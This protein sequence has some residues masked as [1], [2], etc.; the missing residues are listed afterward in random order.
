MDNTIWTKL[1]DRPAM[2]SC[3]FLGLALTLAVAVMAPARA[4]TDEAPLW[5][6]QTAVSPDGATIAF[7]YGGQLYTVPAVGGTAR[8]LTTSDVYA[9]RPVWSPDGNTIAFAADRYGNFDVYAMPAAGGT[10]IRLT[11]H[12]GS[13][14]PTG[15]RCRW[16]L[17]HVR[18]G[19]VWVTP[20]PPTRSPAPTSIGSSTPSRPRAGAN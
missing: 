3:A 1:A 12:S 14:V 13:E 19:P 2:R 4:M 11:T 7:A 10:A 20:P 9:T 15:F 17:C 18:S 8:L 5:L 16:R 6:R